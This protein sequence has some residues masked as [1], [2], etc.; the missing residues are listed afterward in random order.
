[1]VFN[2]GK[3]VALGEAKSVAV[4]DGAEVIDAADKHI[5]PG[6]FDSYS[7]LGLVEIDAVRATRDFAESGDI[8]PNIKAQVGI[9]PDSELLPVTRAN[10]VLLAV[11]APNSRLVAGQSVVLQLDGWTWEELTLK[12]PAGLHIA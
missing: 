8:N 9:N 3:I 7:N 11:S 12:S 1:I 6:L 4:P 10:G 5:Y 2:G